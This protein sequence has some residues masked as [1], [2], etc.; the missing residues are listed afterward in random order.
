M[1]FFTARKSAY[2]TNPRLIDEVLYTTYAYDAP[3][4]SSSSGPHTSPSSKAKRATAKIGDLLGLG[5]PAEDAAAATE[6]EDGTGTGAA[7]R[8]KRK[9]KFDKGGGTAAE[10]FMFAYGTV[11]IWGLSE[12]VAYAVT[13]GSDFAFF[14]VRRKAS[15]RAVPSGICAIWLY[16]YRR[17]SFCKY[18]RHA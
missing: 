4:S 1:K 5:A 12:A 10:V 9:R 14:F 16:T 17:L 6:P 2:H 13:R 18:P 15:R 8:G 3:S 7:A 11:V